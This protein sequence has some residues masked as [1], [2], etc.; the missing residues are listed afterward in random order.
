M[1]CH[2]LSKIKAKRPKNCLSN[3]EQ[4]GFPP[5]AVTNFP[6][7]SCDMIASVVATSYQESLQLYG[8]F[9]EQIEKVEKWLPEGT[10]RAKSLDLIGGDPETIRKELDKLQVYLLSFFWYFIVFN[11]LHRFLKGIALLFC[12]LKSHR[13]SCSD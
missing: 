13:T 3:G 6:S 9:L 12:N 4:D 5:L 10:E 8:E 2:R 11:F 7:Q 1:L